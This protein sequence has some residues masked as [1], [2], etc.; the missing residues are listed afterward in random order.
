MLHLLLLAYLIVASK[1]MELHWKIP[2][3]EVVNESQRHLPVRKALVAGGFLAPVFRL[4]PSRSTKQ[5]QEIRP[6]AKDDLQP[7]T[8]AATPCTL[9]LEF[10]QLIYHGPL[11]WD[12]TSFKGI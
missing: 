8:A 6:S 9:R 11:V 10:A 5:E 1:I 2:G 4:K 7:N 12:L 3:H